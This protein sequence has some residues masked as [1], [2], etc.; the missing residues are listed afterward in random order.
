MFDIE[1]QKKF[2]NN[3]DFDVTMCDGFFFILFSNEVLIYNNLII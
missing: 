1:K 3:Y 2:S